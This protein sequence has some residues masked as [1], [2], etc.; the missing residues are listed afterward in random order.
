MSTQVTYVGEVL[1][2][3]GTGQTTAFVEFQVQVSKA[4]LDAAAAEYNPSSTTS[5]LVAHCRPP[6]RAILDSYL[7][8]LE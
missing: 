6:F 2:D 7:V 3:D 1:V 8:S 4:D 5:P